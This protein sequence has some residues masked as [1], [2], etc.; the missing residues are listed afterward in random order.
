MNKDAKME[1]DV[2][3]AAEAALTPAEQEIFL[4]HF[5]VSD[6]A[7]VSDTLDELESECAF[8]DVTNRIHEPGYPRYDPY[9]PVGIIIAGVYL[10]IG[11]GS[12]PGTLKWEQ[13]SPMIERIRLRL[14]LSC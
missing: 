6:G 10:C 2:F 3:K 7:T 13:V 9:Y 8:N 11:L 5:H 14:D 12:D 4:L 1:K